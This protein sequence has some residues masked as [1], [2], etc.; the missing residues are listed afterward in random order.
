MQGAAS[1]RR[2]RALWAVPEPKNRHT[3]SSRAQP[4]TA[5]KGQRASGVKAAGQTPGCCPAEREAATREPDAVCPVVEA[6]R[7]ESGPV[8]RAGK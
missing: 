5:A 1:F 8:G 6:S 2:A 7:A 3:C 4:S